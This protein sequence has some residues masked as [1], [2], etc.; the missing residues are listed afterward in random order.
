MKTQ[1]LK[2]IENLK[3]TDR[4]KLVGVVREIPKLIASH[5]LFVLPSVTEGFPN[6]VLESLAVGVP[7]VAFGV[8]GIRA[9]LKPG[10]NGTIIAQDDL[11]AFEKSVINACN[12]KWDHSAIKA[13]V[14]TRFGVQ[15]VVKHYEALL[16]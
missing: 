1:V 16:S 12:R 11:G 15:K 13:D 6:V 8:G 3:L 7:V 2:E 4:V 9:M 5:D 10:F 14:E